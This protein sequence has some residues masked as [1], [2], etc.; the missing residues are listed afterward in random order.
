MLFRSIPVQYT[1]VLPDLFKEG[2]GVVVHGR[3]GSGGEFVADE[4]IAKHDEN[5]TPPGLT[6][7]PAKARQTV[8][9]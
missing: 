3:L 5:Y 6:D 1:G 4:V 9:E 7:A 2:K 8:T